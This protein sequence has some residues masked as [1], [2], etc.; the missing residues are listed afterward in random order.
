[1]GFCYDNTK[2]IDFGS[3]EGD[4]LIALNTLAKNV[5]IY[6]VENNTESEKYLENINCIK[7]SKSVEEWLDLNLNDRFDFIM[8]FDV[9]EH[10]REPYK[11]LERL[12]KNHCTHQGVIIVTAPYINTFSKFV[13][14]RI[15]FQYKVEHLFYFSKK[16][17]TYIEKKLKCDRL[18]FRAH[19]K[20]LTVE[21]LLNIGTSFGPKKFIKFIK[22]VRK[23]IPKKTYQ[24]NIKL[25]LGEMLWIIK[26]K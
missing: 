21:Y 18:L 7:Y 11:V 20:I 5:K 1:M 13:L 23:F 3:A 14:N 17:I 24:K 4:N 22:S 8:L 2:I 15:W 10:L 12:L 6:A 19:S 16:S 9:I 25:P 26:N